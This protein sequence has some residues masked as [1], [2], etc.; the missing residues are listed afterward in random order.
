[1]KTLYVDVYFLINFIINML[2]LHFSTKIL[3]IPISV[4]RLIISSAIGGLYAILFALTELSLIA[5]IFLSLSYFVIV[6]FVSM[7]FKHIKRGCILCF[8]FLMLEALFGGLVYY[9]YLLL[10]SFNIGSIGEKYGI[11]RKF[12]TLALI[13]LFVII[14]LNLFVSFFRNKAG[15]KS[16]KISI[17]LFGIKCRC[18]AL[19]DSGNLAKDPMDG[20]PVMLINRE[21]GLK[22]MPLGIPSIDETTNV[23]DRLK[24]RIRII[25]VSYGN[26]SVL[27][28][29]FKADSVYCLTEKGEEKIE[30]TIAFDNDGNNYGGYDALV[31]FSAVE[32]IL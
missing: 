4:R 10:D 17:T 14:L 5:Y 16:I 28:C 29:G 30:L 20:S 12:I 11:N 3:R 21:L 19:V 9:L 18:E 27:L 26:R 6:I 7:G 32:G 23:S 2:S 8:V 15:E 31:P 25:P 24:K 22:L 13:V 1:M